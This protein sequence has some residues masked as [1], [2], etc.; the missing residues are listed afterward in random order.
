MPGPSGDAWAFRAMPWPFR[1]MP[2]PFRAM[3]GLG[4]HRPATRASL[5]GLEH[6]EKAG[7]FRPLK[8]HLFFVGL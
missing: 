6:W 7:A 8:Y 3:R 4:K 1:A 2:W 5:D